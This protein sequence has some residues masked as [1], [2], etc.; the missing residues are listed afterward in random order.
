MPGPTGLL[1]GG[2][3]LD[4]AVRVDGSLALLRRLGPKAKADLVK[5]VA[6]AGNR[7]LKI[8]RATVAYD[9]G[10]MHRLVKVSYSEGGYT[11]EGGWSADDFEAEG[12]PFYPP[13][14]ELGT[15]RQIAQPSIEPAYYEVAA[16]LER[17]VSAILRRNMGRKL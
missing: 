15:S 5:T 13:F 9:T 8:V 17:D 1:I 4:F 12:E 10:R 14:V 7:F 2:A 16:R 11:F 6:Q 3:R